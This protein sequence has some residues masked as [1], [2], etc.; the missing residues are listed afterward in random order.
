M[1]ITMLGTGNALVTECYNTCFILSGNGQN[2]LVDTGG[3]NAILHQ[4][5]H[6]GFS[7]TDIHDVFISH[8]HIDHILGV[9]WIIRI[10]AQLMNKGKFS[11]D[12]N[13]YSHDEVIPL[14]DDLARKL[15]LPYQ[16]EF[17]HSRIHFHTV[18]SNETRKIIGHEV[19][20]F[21]I[22]SERTK[23]FGFIMDYDN[24]KKL[25]F[26]GDEPCNRECECY[27]SGCEWVMHE[28]FCLYSEADIFSPY[29]KHHSTVKDACNTAQRLGVKNLLLYHTEDSDLPHRKERYTAEGRQYYSGNIFVPDDLEIITL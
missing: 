15:L 2:F 17:V 18:N 6:A 29:E 22:N 23:Q 8:S 3:G 5:K 24:G 12:I 19:K 28:A 21:D 11:G 7:L 20:F 4:L 16:Y 27:I 25:A 14:I 26:C 13:I 10:S 1:N 9:I